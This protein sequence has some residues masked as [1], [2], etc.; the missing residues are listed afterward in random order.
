MDDLED[1]RVAITG[2]SSGIGEACALAYA[3]EG[4][5]VAVSARRVDRLERVVGDCRQAGAAD[6]HVRGVDVTDP[7]AVAAWADELAGSG[8]LDVVVA[9]AGIGQYGPFLDRGIEG[10][11]AVVETNLLG[12]LRT[13]H[14]TAP[15]LADGG[16]VQVVGS[17][18]HALPLPYMSVYA[19]SKA[20]VT[21]WTRSVRPELARRGIDLTLLSPGMVRTGFFD[22]IFDDD[23]VPPVVARATDRGVPPGEVAEA[24][25]DAARR[26]PDEVTLTL[27]GRVLAALARLAPRSFARAVERRLRPPGA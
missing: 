10:T 24:S 15:L 22:R 1:L 17:M 26:R 21:S 16:Q 9:N 6:V 23:P 13:V 8:G 2:A 4:C 12:V 7:D 25:V 3:A 20:A 18:S 19:A 5:R 14:A 27:G 11:A